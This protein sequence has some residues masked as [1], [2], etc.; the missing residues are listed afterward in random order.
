ML[1]SDQ[2]VLQR[3]YT[4]QPWVNENKLKETPQTIRYTPKEV[5]I[6][7]PVVVLRQTQIQCEERINAMRQKCIILPAE[8]FFQYTYNRIV[9][10]IASL[11]V[12]KPIEAI[13]QLSSCRLKS[14][15]ISNSNYDKSESYRAQNRITRNKERQKMGTL[16]SS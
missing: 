10:L 11:D 1:S 6:I 9:E 7:T 16:K 13:Y 8:F 12:N 14:S 5:L 15:I 4:Y 2:H 3:Y